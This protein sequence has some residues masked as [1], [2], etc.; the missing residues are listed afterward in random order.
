MVDSRGMVAVRARRLVARA[1][2][3]FLV[4][5]S[6]WVQQPAAPARGRLRSVGAEIARWQTL[7]KR[8]RSPYRTRAALFYRRSLETRVFTL[9]QNG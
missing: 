7:Y 8:A 6:L 5:G 4:S 9:A 2:A 1:A 3:A